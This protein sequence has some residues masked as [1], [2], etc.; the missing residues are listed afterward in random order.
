MAGRILHARLHL[1]DRQ[2]VSG[3]SRR[4]LCKV[5]DVEIDF[6][7]DGMPYVSALLSGPAA[8]GPRMPGLLGRVM[9]AVHRRLH[10]EHDPVPNRVPA[11][12]IT[13]IEAAVHVDDAG[14]PL[15]VQG[16]GEWVDEQIISTIPGA[17]H[18]TQ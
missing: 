1:L 13:D 17:D 15:G 12:R 2:V 5:D 9:T 10:A 8:L 14:D 3:H 4:M 18:E 16:F 7:D 6:T 11:T